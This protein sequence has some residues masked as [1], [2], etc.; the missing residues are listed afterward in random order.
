MPED[1]ARAPAGDWH[2]RHRH[3][4][5]LPVVT[6]LQRLARSKHSTDAGGYWFPAPMSKGQ[7]ST[8]RC[9]L[10]SA[11]RGPATGSQWV[12]QRCLLSASSKQARGGG[13]GRGSG[14]GPPLRG[15]P[16]TA[17]L[18]GRQ[19]SAELQGGRWR[20]GCR[21]SRTSAAQPR[22]AGCRLAALHAYQ[23]AL[24]TLWGR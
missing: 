15:W 10:S 5:R 11:S 18:R 13:A 14:P 3:S 20:W 24:L 7:S 4:D 8:W 19:G 22:A 1:S 21:P 17:G 2:P 6:P 9:G 23:Q 12:T 16:G